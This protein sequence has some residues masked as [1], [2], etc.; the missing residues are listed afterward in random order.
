[1]TKPKDLRRKTLQPCFIL[2]KALYVPHVY[3]RNEWVTYGGIETKTLKQLKILGAELT[4]KY[5]FE[6]NP[7]TDWISGAKV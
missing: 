3:R 5:L 1:M 7:L 6:Q 4:H 2:G